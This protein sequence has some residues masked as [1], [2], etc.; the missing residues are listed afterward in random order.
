MLHI[1]RHSTNSASLLETCLNELA[2]ND[3]LL[4]IEDGIYHSLNP[5]A[6]LCQLAELKRLYVLSD[7]LKARGVNLKIGQ[8]IEMQA[9]VELTARHDNSLTW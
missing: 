3:D 5:S 8:L 2:P 1:Y 7:D 9:W 6:A 4:L